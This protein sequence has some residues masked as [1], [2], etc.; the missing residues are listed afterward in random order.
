[1][2][3]VAVQPRPRV[4]RRTWQFDLTLQLPAFSSA[5]DVHLVF[6]AILEDAQDNRSIPGLQELSCSDD[7]PEDGGTAHISGFLQA[8]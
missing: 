1:M 3:Q 6:L 4:R 8:S 7:V 5:E 2:A